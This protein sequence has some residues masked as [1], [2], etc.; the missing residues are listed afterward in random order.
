MV[1]KIKETE[2]E[3]ILPSIRINLRVHLLVR[4]SQLNFRSHFRIDEIV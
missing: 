1:R 4:C 2:Q 3:T